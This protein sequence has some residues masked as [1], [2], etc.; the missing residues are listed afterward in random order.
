[1]IPEGSAVRKFSPAPKEHRKQM[2]KKSAFFVLVFFSLVLL[3]ENAEPRNGWEGVEFGAY[4]KARFIGIVN[5]SHNQEDQDG[6]SV[7]NARLFI[8]NRTKEMNWPGR[9]LYKLEVDIASGALDSKDIYLGW[10]FFPELVVIFGQS[11]VPIGWAVQSSEFMLQLAD[12]P[13]L[14][15]L[16]FNRDRGLKLGGTFNLARL[17][18]QNSDFLINYD[19]GIFNGEGLGIQR[20]ANEKFIYAGRFWL[21]P[22]GAVGQDESDL[23]VCSPEGEAEC[24]FSNRIR[25]SLGGAVA[26]DPSNARGGVF[27]AGM[28]KLYCDLEARL[29]WHGLSLVSEWLQIKVKGDQGDYRQKAL[30]AQIGYLLPFLKWVEPVYRYEYFDYDDRPDQNEKDFQSRQKNAFGFNFYFIQHH[31][32]LQLNYVLTDLQE[33]IAKSPEGDPLYGD[34]VMVQVQIGF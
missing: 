6:F 26:Y 33:G 12:P 1:M 22:I 16:I 28:E 20:N 21:E 11:K 30:Y 17:R 9:I 3:T 29:K 19:L 7:Q 15:D 10:K 18:K 5:T 13:L 8:Q 34:E 27:D 2:K 25:F 24:L 4:T 23:P 32:E 14:K 31:A